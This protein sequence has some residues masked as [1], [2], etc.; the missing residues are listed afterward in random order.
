ML[1][2]VDSLTDVQAAKQELLGIARFDTLPHPTVL[3]PE[4]R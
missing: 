2:S 3:L 1:Q 4:T